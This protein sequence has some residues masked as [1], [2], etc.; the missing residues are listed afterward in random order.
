MSAQGP[1]RGRAAPTAGGWPR[2]RPAARPG[3]R[4][5][6]R[7]VI[8]GCLALFLLLG[9]R[10]GAV[11][12]EQYWSA[13]GFKKKPRGT[14]TASGVG[15][16]K[17]HPTREKRRSKKH[18]KKPGVSR[19]RKASP[20][21]APPPA[22]QPAPP[23]P[24][25]PAPA[26]PAPAEPAPAEPAPGSDEQLPEEGAAPGGEEPSERWYEAGVHGFFTGVGIATVTNSRAAMYGVLPLQ[27]S[28][29]AFLE[30]NAQP[31]FK[32][33]DGVF[34]AFADVSLYGATAAPER[35]VL[36]NEAYVSFQLGPVRL[37][38]GRQRLVWGSGLTVNPTDL[39]DPVKN[40]LDVEQ[41]R[42]GAFLLPLAEVSLGGK[43]T[44]S[45]LLSPRYQTN[46]WA[47]PV[48][49]QFRDSIVGGRLYALLFD[50][51]TNFI[52]Y[53]DLEL[54]RNYYGLSLSRYFGDRLEL[55]VE[56]LGW[57]GAPDPVPL[58]QI[59]ACGP[60]P[61]STSAALTVNAVGGARLQLDD[62]SF[63]FLEYYYNGD[64]L[65]GPEFAALQPQLGCI[66]GAFGGVGPP[67]P[68]PVGHPAVPALVVLRTHYLMVGYLRPHLWSDVLDDLSVGLTAVVGL[69]DG[70]VLP[71]LQIGYD[72]GGRASIGLRGGL[73]LGPSGSEFQMSATQAIA[74]A[75]VKIVY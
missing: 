52:Y 63:G 72:F 69:Q 75:D 18:A 11:A 47:L 55:H 26:E 66:A 60:L 23:V 25:P 22:V 43:V 7:G 6:R 9:T 19:V 35:L 13:Y 33:K 20:V 54:D 24:I 10:P 46:S 65:D 39:L 30:A 51:D 59:P 8:L 1:A 29:Q 73:W 58:P 36:I 2:R 48:S 70:S 4:D 62:Q 67:L 57:K 38:A 27:A 50:A 45:A 44:F 53:R 5:P 42:T 37:L 28:P 3:F 17:S 12:L 32:S 34:D 14:G 61:Q 41:Q 71:L 68:N 40:P 56:A 31:R 49:F 16:K 64:G 74:M 21:L 15:S